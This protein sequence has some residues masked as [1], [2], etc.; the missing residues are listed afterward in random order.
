MKRTI[1]H[2]KASLLAGAIGDALG[3]PIEFRSY[4]AIIDE[5]GSLGCTKFKLNYQGIAEITDDTQMT[6]FTLEGIVNYLYLKKFTSLEESIYQSYLRWNKTQSSKYGS[7]LPANFD[8]MAYPQLFHRRS[9][10]HTC[11]SAL[12]SGIMGS[13]SKPINDS[14]GCGGVMRVAPIGY[15][16]D[17]DQAFEHGCASAA[18]THGHPLGYL[19][20]GAFAYLMSMI[21]EGEELKSSVAQT[22]AKLEPIRNAQLQVELLKMALYLSQSDES[23]IQCIKKLGEG[24]V[25]EEALAISVF[26]S[27]R[28]ESDLNRALSVSVTHD[29]DSDSTGSITGN[30]LG[31]YLGMSAINEE[32]LNVL[33]VTKIV[34]NFCNCVEHHDKS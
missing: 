14:K 7:F 4:E 28:Y 3:W 2:L 12:S 22:I 9:P 6:L 29:G 31:A 16:Y 24:W 8:L 23:D 18:I 5:Y 30:I 13:V 25:G 17:K 21:F 19:S 15:F 34:I 32:W 33:E 1:E 10:G 20:A 26:C 27:L 11:T